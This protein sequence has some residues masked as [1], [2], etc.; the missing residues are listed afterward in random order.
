MDSRKSQESAPERIELAA[1][2]RRTLNLLAVPDESG[3]P[4]VIEI[5]IPADERNRYTLSGYF[6]DLG[7]AALAAAHWDGRVTAIYVSLNRVHPRLLARAANR[8]KK[9]GQ[10]TSDQHIMR[11]LWL[12]LDFDPQRPAGIASIDTEHERSLERAAMAA[13][14]L[15]EEYDWPDPVFC[16]SGNGGHLLYRI[17]LPHNDE[18]TRLI[19]QTLAS[20]ASLFDDKP[21]GADIVITLDKTVSNAARITKLYGTVTAKGDEIEDNP[22]RRSA[23]LGVPENLSVLTEQQ[24]KA[25]VEAN[26][27]PA[28]GESP[29]T[30]PGDDWIDTW[31]TKVADVVKVKQGPKPYSGGRKWILE[32]CLFNPEHGAGTDV[33]IIQYRGGALKYKCSHDSCKDRAWREFRQKVESD[34]KHDLRR[35]RWTESAKEP[36]PATPERH[37]GPLDWAALNGKTPPERK[38]AIPLWIAMNTTT[39]L[40]GAGGVGKTLLAQILSS[41]IATGKRYISANDGPMNV[42]MVACEDDDDE[43][44]RRQCAISSYLGLQLKDFAEHFTLVSRVGLDNTI[45][46]TEFGRVIWTPFAGELKEQIH[47]LKARLV[48]LDNAAQLTTD[49]INRHN[50]TTFCNFLRGLGP[51]AGLDTAVVLLAHPSRGNKEFSGSTAWENCVRAR[52]YLGNNLPD[53]PADDEAEPN[54]DIR[55]LCRRKVNYGPKDFLRFIYR[56][57]VLVPDEPAP[58]S[59]SSEYWR[60]ERARRVVLESL[61]KLISLG[62][63]PIDTYNSPEYL[64]KLIL[65]FKLAEGLTKKELKDAMNE[66]MVSGKIRRMPAVWKYSHGAPRDGLVAI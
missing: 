19:E 48:F 17:D 34:T 14:W 55:F 47:D 45:M 4:S 24:I 65:E 49:E 6:N 61:P 38:Y 5:R 15:S 56:N 33:C 46:S 36:S 42:L 35:E 16:D 44:W 30:E 52:M 53:A 21:N 26:P 2:I 29:S 54:S 62:K 3:E 41:A 18:S 59:A 1:V 28:S 8:L 12:L 13:N 57:G 50:V 32:S 27:A 66:L 11:R 40:A 10:A 37:A 7:A 31:L 23:I 25:F 58:E 60:A 39:L 20:I 51:P 22:H 43:L 64:P 63:R 9:A